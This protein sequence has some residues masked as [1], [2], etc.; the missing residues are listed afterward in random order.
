MHKQMV[1]V[2]ATAAIAIP[3]L[4]GSK[5]QGTT[6]L[7]EFQPA[8]I[9]DK[10]SKHTKH[11]VFDL[12]FDAG[13]NEYVCRTRGDKSTNAAEFVV[14]TSVNYEIDGQKVKIKTPDKKSLEC[15]IVRASLA[16]AANQ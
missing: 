10:Q 9:P 6:T 2:V 12:T 7:K 15:K 3:A 5:Q 14:G 13:T 8:G 11:Q 16:S 1:V 4:G